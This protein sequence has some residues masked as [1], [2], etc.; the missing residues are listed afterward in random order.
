MSGDNA[1][2][3]REFVTKVLAT[4]DLDRADE[5]VSPEVVVHVPVRPEPLRGLEALKRY[6][7]GF[8]AALP[9]VGFTVEDEIV[10]DDRVVLRV[11]VHG[12]HRGELLGVPPTGRYVRVPEVLILRFAE[13]RIVE[14]WVSV[15]L[16]G[17]LAQLDALPNR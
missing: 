8:R 3:A 10:Q 16:L 12:T 6:I 13:G 4:G 5:L 2:L 14:D 11:T 1:R 7:A 15:D 17:L 9:D